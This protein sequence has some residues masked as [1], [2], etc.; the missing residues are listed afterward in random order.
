M[1][2]GLL[3]FSELHKDI[4]VACRGGFVPRHRS[5]DA[6]TGYAVAFPDGTKIL[7]DPGE[8][9]HRYSVRLRPSTYTLRHPVLPGVGEGVIPSAHE[10]GALPGQGHCSQKR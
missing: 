9:M 1:I 3:S 5:K 2:E 6:D 4:D 7:P 8:R 10:R